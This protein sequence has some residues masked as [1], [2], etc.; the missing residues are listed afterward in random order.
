MLDSQYFV[1]PMITPRA[2]PVSVATQGNTLAQVFLEL[3]DARI[4]EHGAHL[5]VYGYNDIMLSS[6][7]KGPAQQVAVCERLLRPVL[8][9]LMVIQGFL[10]SADS[11]G[12]TI[13]YGANRVRVV[14]DDL[15][16]AKTR[17]NRLV[18]HLA[19]LGRLL[20]MVPI[21]GLVHVGRPGKSNHLG[22]SL[23][24]RSDPGELET[25]V[26]G[27]PPTF[28]RVHVVDASVFPSVPAT[29]ITLSVMANSHRIATAAAR[30]ER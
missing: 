2:A 4:L 29:T 17:V 9:R 15:T 1:I 16:A 28:E 21:P 23:R 5:Q 14:G 8:G 24:M 20:G 18:R 22:G 30:L 6:L 25:D 11:P 7:A 12:L 26:L 3:E 19:S 27:R 13:S 10:H